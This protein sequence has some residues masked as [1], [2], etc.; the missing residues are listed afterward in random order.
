[1]GR[2]VG[3]D[4]G[5]T[6]TAVAYVDEY[7]KP[8]VLKNSD[9]QT[10]TPSAVFFDPPNYVVG[11]VAL[12][13]TLTDPDRV[14]Q[15]VKRFM[16]VKEHRIHVAGEAYSPEFVSSLIL[17]KVVQ[18]AQDEMGE[19][20]TQ[21]VIT[22]PAYFT[23]SQRHATYE[24][25]QMAGLQVLRII[26]EPTAAALAY[27]ISRRGK[28]RNI[29]VYDLGGGTFDV[30][31]LAIDNDSLN[32]IAVGGDP[33]L[34]GKDFDDRI[35]NFIEDELREKYGFEMDTDASLE[36][37]LRLKAEAAKRQLTARQSVPITL[38]V[39]R[40]IGT[41]TGTMDTFIPVRVELTREVYEQFTADL[42]TRTELLLENVM[43]QA[44]MSWSDISETLCVGGSSRMPMV[45]E[46]LTRLS[47]RRPLLHDPDE[48]VAKGAALQAALIAKDD[49]V[50]EVNVGHVLAHSLGVA[51]VKD[52]RTV[53]EH[54]I[55]SLTPL[56]CAQS[57]D[58]Y[59][60]TFDNQSIVQIRVYEGESTDPAAYAN[61]PIG[62]FNLDVSPPRPKGQPKITVEFRCDE[63]GRITALARD[64][65]TGKE[66]RSLIALTGARNE[67]EVENEAALLSSA[68]IS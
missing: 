67:N 13:S 23:E 44:N 19:P 65:D 22:V 32:V 56:P 41:G 5:T 47:G 21:A 31:I 25:G 52:G 58:G 14:V 1:V 17:R 4:L 27:G 66:S 28:R 57:R 51:T 63:N 2:A 29:L 39:K 60:T 30:T 48:C 42:L 40:S 24:A 18:E 15:F 62:V 43:A 55:P 11:E 61:G 37:E 9:G 45:R 6:Y 26:N 46:M 10:T 54:V 59:T 7:G 8:V 49:T 64:R 50:A 38:K 33:H 34:G 12:Q 53:I 3:I 20:V 16:G 36:A 68:V 35:M